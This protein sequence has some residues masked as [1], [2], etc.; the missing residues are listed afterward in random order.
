VAGDDEECVVDAD[1]KEAWERTR[2]F[3]FNGDPT[4]KQFGVG[5]GVA[6]AGDATHVRCFSIEGDEWFRE[7]DAASAAPEAER[8]LIST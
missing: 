4:V 1:I 7:R 5:M 8:T 2:A 3:V 6:G